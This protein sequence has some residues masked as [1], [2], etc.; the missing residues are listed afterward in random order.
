MLRYVKLAGVII[1]T[2]MEL[3][4]PVGVAI[5]IDPGVTLVLKEFSPPIDQRDRIDASTR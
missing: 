3:W 5:L 4:M 1:P 2:N